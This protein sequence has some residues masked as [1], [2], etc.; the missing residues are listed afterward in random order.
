MS[1]G[2]ADLHL[3][4]VTSDG[5]Q[6]LAQMVARARASGLGTIAITD[7]DAIS[8]ELT[9]RSAKLQGIEVITGVELKADFDG[10]SGELLGYFVDPAAARLL[11]LL[12]HMERARERRMD[13]MLAKCRDAGLDVGIDDV[14]RHAQGNL[15]RPHLA[16]AL[17]ESGLAEDT[18]DVFAR[19]IGRG[20]PCFV[21]IEKVGFREAIEILRA[22]G[23]AVSVAH[24]CLMRVGDW[25]RFLTLLASAG[26]HGLETVYPYR[27]SPTTELTTSPALLAAK[28]R[29][30][31]FLTTGGSDDH[32]LGSS[33]VTLGQIRLEDEHVEA[34]RKVCGA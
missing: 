16:R 25:D 2:F 3:H 28:A 11:E 18:D 12:A 5:T 19:L 33:K 20:R 6:T 4:T 27:T 29:E 15:G 13:L 10:V 1:A 32:G 9:A 24:P 22:A 23:A 14:R 31:G 8:P 30:R 26:V 34:L 21:P 7:H 17:V